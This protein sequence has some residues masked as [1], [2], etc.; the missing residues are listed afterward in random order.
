[1]GQPAHPAGQVIFARHLP[2]DK[3]CQK[4]LSDPVIA[5]LVEHCSA[6]TEA[7]SLNPVEALKM[8]V[9]LKN[10]QLLQ[11]QLQLR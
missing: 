3:F 1:M 10:L 8:F 7:M 9:G 5:Q 4:N 2:R 11:L 6:K